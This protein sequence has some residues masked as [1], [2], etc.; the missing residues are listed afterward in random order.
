MKGLEVR[1]V[2]VKCFQDT[3][4]YFLFFSGFI[5][6]T[7]FFFSRYCFS[8]SIFLACFLSSGLVTGLG[9]EE[10]NFNLNSLPY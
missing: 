8:L 3:G 5:F 6:L 1:R 7:F 9:T 4:K 10:E 2:R